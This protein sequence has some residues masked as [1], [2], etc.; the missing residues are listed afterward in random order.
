MAGNTW[1]SDYPTHIKVPPVEA[2]TA[3]IKL[4][5]MVENS[6][7]I[8]DDFVASYK[9]PRQKN[10]INNPRFRNMPKFY[11]TSCNLRSEPLADLIAD[12]PQ[13][14]SKKIIALGE[15]DETHG[16]LHQDHE[17]HVSVWFYDGVYPKGFQKI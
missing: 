2:K 15:V 7:P 5:R 8:K 4:Y 11:G 16:L 13:K 12:H 10:L 14:F 17:T 1:P 9:D 3:K 6:P